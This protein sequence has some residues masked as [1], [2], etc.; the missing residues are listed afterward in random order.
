MIEGICIA[1]RALLVIAGFLLPGLGWVRA[2]RW[3]APWLTA[4][5][6]S[7]LAI[8]LGVVGLAVAGVA[9]TVWSLGAWLAV[10]AAGGA[11]MWWRRSPGPEPGA[12][13]APRA[14][15]EH[16]EWFLMLPV[17]PLVAVALWRAATQP[18]SGADVDFRWNFLAEL[19]VETGHLGYYP[20]VRA[21]DFASY[22]WAD[23][24]PPLV[25]SI[26]AWTYLAAG[27]MDRHWTV[28]PVL[29]QVAGMLTL[30]RAL[31]REW[32]G[33]RGGALAMGCTGATFVLQFA[34]NLGQET[35]LT[36][37]GAGAMTYH[38]AI[39]LRGR[40]A[41]TLLAAVIGAAVAGCAREY[42]L[43]FAGAGV[44]W[45]VLEGGGTRR[46]LGFGA[47]ATL[48]PG[49]WFLRNFWRS[50]NPL[51]ALDVGGA[52]PANP[53]FSA[54][55]HGYA[56]I[57]GAKLREGSD[58]GEALRFFGIGALPALLGL[59]GA[60]VFCRH[61]PGWRGSALLVGAGTACWLASVPYTAGGFFYSMRVLSPVLL[62]GCAWAGAL[63][64]TPKLGT[65]S[66][67]TTVLVLVLAS[68][69]AA[70]RALTVPANPYRVT[71]GEWSRVGYVL[72]D[73]FSRRDGP[74]LEAMAATVN[75]KVLSES[76]GAQ[77]V[78][79][80]TG[81]QLIPIW[82]PEVAFLFGRGAVERAPHRLVELGFTHVLLTRVRSSVEFLERTGAMN[83]LTGHLRVVMTNE[84]F[85]LFAI[86][87][88]S[89]PLPP[90]P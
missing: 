48:V 26:Y 45:V 82:S 57:Y 8:F 83:R 49:W 52:F 72:Q 87:T 18:L 2:A 60:T 67:F 78:F 20:P 6:F 63:L 58:W 31:G 69:D 85:V 90:F 76:A 55:M 1:S 46:A 27:S 17:V 36:A 35:G 38:L 25:S 79:R 16:A 59:L 65:R 71:P 77:R 61:Q 28:L 44:A 51:V 12:A 47:L 68:G 10:V 13:P 33:P 66:R 5:L 89:N 74:F 39:Y 84:S 11:A 24:I 86:T 9:V 15:G 22:F 21:E 34:F 73:E 30:T 80:A 88:E 43:A 37:L 32:G 54:W 40:D 3:P 42:G 64:A 23:G 53:V 81:K 70:L 29:A 75:G 56:E 50:G 4:G 41:R 62:I 14:K 7:A 19:I